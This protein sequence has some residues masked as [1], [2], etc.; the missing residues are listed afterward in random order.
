MIYIGGFE[1]PDKNAAAQRVISNAKALH[2]TGYNII[3]VDI[4]RD[5][6]KDILETKSE[7]F[8]FTRY[9]MKYTNKRLISITDLIAI[10]KIYMN[11]QLYIIRAYNYPGIALLKM[12]RYCKKIRIKIF[13]QL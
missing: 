9:S 11:D 2:E 1:L 12:L 10:I 7:C 3:L 6:E 13:S 4:D 8:G 5:C